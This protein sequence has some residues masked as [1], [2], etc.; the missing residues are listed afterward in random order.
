MTKSNEACGA[1][2]ELWAHLR[3]HNMDIASIYEHIYYLGSCL[4]STKD[5]IEDVIGDH[6]NRDM[7]PSSSGSFERMFFYQAISHRP[8]A[9]SYMKIDKD[10]FSSAAARKF[11]L[12]REQVFGQQ[13]RT[14]TS[15]ASHFKELCKRG[16]GKQMK[17]QRGS[18]FPFLLW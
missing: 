17:H 3:N 12:D 8:Q 10:D 5:Q 9:G 6:D 11:S 18:L 4:F 13:V 1:F 7:K 15:L 16:Q 2:Q 14:K